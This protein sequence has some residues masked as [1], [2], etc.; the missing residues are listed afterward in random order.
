[1][2]AER[3]KSPHAEGEENSGDGAFF[4]LEISLEIVINLGAQDMEA[5]TEVLRIAGKMPHY[6]FC[7]LRAAER[8]LLDFPVACAVVGGTS[9]S[10]HP[11]PSCRQQPTSI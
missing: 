6:K 9:F 3:S 8:R 4:P 10:L 2:T 1:M 11:N 7:L 5:M